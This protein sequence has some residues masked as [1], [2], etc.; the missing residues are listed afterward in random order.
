MRRRR[1]SRSKSSGN[2]GSRG[3]VDGFPAD[4][5]HVLHVAHRGV[6]LD[7]GRRPDPRDAGLGAEGDAEVRAGV[8]EDDGAV[9]T[10]FF[11]AEKKK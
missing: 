1:K 7:V 6:V 8:A 5:V 2:R 9:V 3:E 4:D 10:V 11:L